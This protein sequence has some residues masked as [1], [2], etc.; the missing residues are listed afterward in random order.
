MIVREHVSLAP[1]TTLKIGGPA[2]FFIDVENEEEIREATRFAREQHLSL[3]VLGE[4]SN[5]LVPDIG[6]EGVVVK[7]G[8]RDITTEDQNESILITAGAGALWDVVVDEASAH[9]FF[10]IENLGG[11]PGSIGGAV[12]QNIGAY[13]A[14]LSTIFEYADVLDSQ[15]LVERRIQVAEANFAYRSSFFKTHPELIIMR[16]ALRLQKKSEANLTYPDLIRAR[17]NGVLLSSAREVAQAVR[18]IRALKFP[19][20]TEGGSAGSFFKN[21]TISL[22]L[23][24]SLSVRFPGLPVFPQK[25]DSV[26]IS[27]AW[28]LDRGLSL[29]GLTNGFAR[30]YEN[31][32][33]VIVARNGACAADIDAL[34]I[35]VAARVYDAIGIHIEREVE[36]FGIKFNL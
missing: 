3:Y 23:S 6:V 13:G 22:E 17:T 20:A 7:I 2:R 16:V 5:V 12:V 1:Y 21:P 32:P 18:A 10:G 19:Q 14:E 27:L 9:D 25:N 36:T 35:E 34:A 8:L 33:L 4:G 11:I 30:L 15:T 28:L 26:K 24:K 29:K 31:Q